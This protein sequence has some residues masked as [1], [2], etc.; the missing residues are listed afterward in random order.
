MK[1]FGL[2]VVASLALALVVRAADPQVVTAQGIL[3]KVTKDA[4]TLRPRGPDGRFEKALL[5]KLTGTSKI[6]TLTYQKR[7]GQLVPVQK[8]TDARDL[9]PR[10]TL[11]VIYA[12]T[13]E[14]ATLLAAVVQPPGGK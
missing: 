1:R 4:L 2:A 6:S 3:D 13:E 8:D 7:A 12:A 5:L 9:E 14:G 11:A 10:Q